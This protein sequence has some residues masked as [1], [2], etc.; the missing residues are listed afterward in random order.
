MPA[1]TALLLLCFLSAG[2]TSVVQSPTVV[3]PPS[4]PTVT[5]GERSWTEMPLTD[6]EEK[7][8]FSLHSFGAKPVILL[9]VSDSC[10]SCIN[11]LNR[12][13]GEIGQLPAVR[14]KTIP[15]VVLD[16]DPP[17]DPGY[18][19]KYHNQFSF[20]GYTARASP[21]MTLQLLHDLG[22]F[23]IDP[24]TIPVIL[25]CPGGHEVLLPPGLK[26]AGAFDILQSN[27]C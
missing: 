27:E 8:I 16:I 6:L 3:A 7:G 21:S 12:E 11:L 17:G 13:I 22:P 18:I 5:E 23:A 24:Q 20:T 25:I 1:M 9:V 10:P 15:F 19:A 4:S 26:P 2:C 14:N